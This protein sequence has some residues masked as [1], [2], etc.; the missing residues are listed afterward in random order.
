MGDI[1]HAGFIH[2]IPTDQKGH[3]Y[4]LMPDGRIEVEDPQK[5]FFITKGLPPGAQSPQP[6]QMK[7]SSKP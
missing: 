7:P 1:E 3:P 2:G 5:I 6:P 4:K